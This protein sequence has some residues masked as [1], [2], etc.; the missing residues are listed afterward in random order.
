MIR[1][2]FVAVL[3][4]CY[5]LSYR[6]LLDQ[7]DL[8]TAMSPGRK[9]H[10]SFIWATS[11]SLGSSSTLLPW[12]HGKRIVC[13]HAKLPHCRPRKSITGRIMGSLHRLFYKK[14][15]NSLFCFV[16]IS[17][18]TFSHHCSPSQP[19]ASQIQWAKANVLS[20]FLHYKKKN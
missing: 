4:D 15:P 3:L 10:L 6:M 14:G 20:I 2:D 13:L 12:C 17:T 9:A 1:W 5:Q 18:G 7:S 19:H 16:E 8:R 11:L